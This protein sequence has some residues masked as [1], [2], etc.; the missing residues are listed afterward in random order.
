MADPPVARGEV[1]LW[2]AARSPMTA[3]S[4]SGLLWATGTSCRALGTSPSTCP[5]TRAGQPLL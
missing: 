2:V 3:F 5:R 1:C 4:G